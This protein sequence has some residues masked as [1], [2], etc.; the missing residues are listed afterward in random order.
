MVGEG[1]DSPEPCAEAVSFACLPS[2]CLHYGYGLGPHVRDPR[3]TVHG[4]HG[5][6][7]E[8]ERASLRRRVV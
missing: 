8:P 1:T 4:I 3:S 5:M 7:H 6:V 2:A